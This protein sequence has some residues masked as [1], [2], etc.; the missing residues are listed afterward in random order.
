M[1]DIPITY[2]YTSKVSVYTFN[3]QK[4]KNILFVGDLIRMEQKQNLKIS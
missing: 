1:F 4:E 2:Y 3:E